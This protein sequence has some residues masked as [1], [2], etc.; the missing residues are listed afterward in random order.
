V[1]ELASSFKPDSGEIPK[2]ARKADIGQIAVQKV[3][4]EIRLHPLPSLD[5]PQASGEQLFN[6]GP[7]QVTYHIDSL[8]GRAEIRKVT[9]L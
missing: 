9:A 7:V 5:L 8:T 2:L 3:E 4:E 1:K 6:F